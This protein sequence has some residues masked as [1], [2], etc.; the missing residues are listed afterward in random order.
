MIIAGFAVGAEQGFIYV[1]A[2]YPLA[3]ERL[4]TAIR[5]AKQ[6]GLLGSGVFESPLNFNIDIRIGAGAFVCGEET[7]LIRS[8]E[9]RRGRPKPRP[10]YPSERG[11]WGMPTV[12]NNV[13]TLANVAPILRKGS[14]WFSSIGTAKSTGTKVFALAGKIQNTG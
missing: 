8:I 12:I 7:A 1:R 2:E 4:Q 13:E 14:A 11:L 9:G 3:I 10:P 5:Q 6:M